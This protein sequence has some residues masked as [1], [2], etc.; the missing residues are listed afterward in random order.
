MSAGGGVD[1]KVS[2][3]VCTVQLEYVMLRAQG[4]TLNCAR[5]STGIEFRFG[6]GGGNRNWLLF[7]GR[8]TNFAN[9]GVWK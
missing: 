7:R 8:A 1:R 3:A 6:G 5:V 4:D 9:E 2:V